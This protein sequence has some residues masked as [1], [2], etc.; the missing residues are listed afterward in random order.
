MVQRLGLY[1][2]IWTLVHKKTDQ[3][4]I[5]SPTPSMPQFFLLV[6]KEGWTPFLYKE[7]C[8]HFF[9]I[10]F[11]QSRFPYMLLELL[12]IHIY[13]EQ[14]ILSNSFGGH[15]RPR[16]TWMIAGLCFVVLSR[17]ECTVSVIHRVLSWSKAKAQPLKIQSKLI[18]LWPWGLVK[19]WFC[20]VVAVQQYDDGITMGHINIS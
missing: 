17:P 16:W 2:R 14:C 20:I 10:F 19:W 1:I 12:C 13:L 7:K 9:F 18:V 11:I 15:I 3:S 6:S 8:N 5:T 4:D